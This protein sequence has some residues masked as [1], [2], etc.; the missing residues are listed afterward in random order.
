[1]GLP[2]ARLKGRFTPFETAVRETAAR[3]G[4]LAGAGRVVAAVSGG[5]DSMALL[6]ALARIRAVDGSWPEVAVAHLDHA[7]RGEASREDAEFVAEAARRLGL[8][9]VVER[10]DVAAEASRRRRNVEAVARDLRYAF[11]ERAARQL[12]ASAVA[13][14]HTASDQAE[15]VLMRLA[16]GA[17]PDGLAGIAPVRSLGESV[18][19]VR[20]LLG[21]TREEAL[22][23]CAERGI[24]YRVDAT[25]EDLDLTRAFVRAEI[26]PRLE[27]VAPGAATSLARA[28]ELAADDRDFFAERVA[29][30][31]AA[32]DAPSEGAVGL[33]AAEVARL[34]P[35]LRRRVLREAVRRA[36]GDLLRLSR[37]HVEA[38][39]RLLGPGRGGREASLPLGVRAKRAGPRLVVSVFVEN[40][41]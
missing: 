38:L 10:A 7:L 30:L 32:W 23:Y 14:G 1:M 29:E 40:G 27:R 16:R 39:E 2:S 11:L 3:H 6:V 28:A 22:A 12:G 35:A 17:G 20:P 13:T 8:E 5:A 37:E 33:P 24:G 9:A 15:T 34:H 18:R 26:L 31:F 4:M 25:N 36:R 41:C 19:L 21:V